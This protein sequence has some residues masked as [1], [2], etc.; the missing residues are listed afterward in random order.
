VRE[1]AEITGLQRF[2]VYELI[3]QQRLPVLKIGSTFRVAEDAL[4]AWIQRESQQGGA[5]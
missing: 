4:A 2:R 1:V 5:R 3:R